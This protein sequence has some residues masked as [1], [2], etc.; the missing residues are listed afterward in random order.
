[1]VKKR[2]VR[3]STGREGPEGVLLYSFYNLGA[4]GGCSRPQPDR[5]IPWKRQGTHCTGGW[6]RNIPPTPG[7]DHRTVQSVAT[8][9]TDR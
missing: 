9:Y 6:T 4:R 3:R 7:F 8:C 5:F 2:E 1:M